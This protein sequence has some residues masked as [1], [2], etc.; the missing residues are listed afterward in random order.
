MTFSSQEKRSI[1]QDKIGN[2]EDAKLMRQA[3]K[4][5]KIMQNKIKEE[6]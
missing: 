4:Q 1:G 6:I 3:A 5:N 2:D